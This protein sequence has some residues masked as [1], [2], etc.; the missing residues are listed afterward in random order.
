LLWSFGG[1][2]VSYVLSSLLHKH[3]A[4]LSDLNKIKIAIKMYVGLMEEPPTNGMLE[5]K[6]RWLQVQNMQRVNLG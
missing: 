6:L 1:L 4:G 2:L 3:V 5:T